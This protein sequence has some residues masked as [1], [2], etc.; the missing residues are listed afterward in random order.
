MIGLGGEHQTQRRGTRLPSG[1][2]S[3]CRGATSFLDPAGF[4]PAR[5]NKNNQGRRHPLTAGKPSRCRGPTAYQQIKNPEGRTSETAE[6]R[7]W[8]FPQGK[9][10]IFIFVM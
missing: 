3:R 9:I 7:Q 10:S 4:H 8:A 2:R 1:A 5:D 6:G